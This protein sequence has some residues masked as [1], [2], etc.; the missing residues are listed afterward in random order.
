MTLNVAHSSHYISLFLTTTPKHMD[1]FV[2][3]WHEFKN[4][5][6]VETGTLHSQLF[7]NSH[8]HFINVQ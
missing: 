6:I 8:F 7:T 3:F 2:P 4:S 1:A 5:I